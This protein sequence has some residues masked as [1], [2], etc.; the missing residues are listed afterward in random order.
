MEFKRLENE[1]DE[2][3]IY[4]VCSQKDAIGTWDDVKD[5]LNELLDC[6]YGESTYRKKFQAFQK[7]M[8]AN[9]HKFLDDDNYIKELR[10]E[11][12]ELAKEK[13][14]LSDER[15]ELNRQIRE[16]A[17]KESYLDM[18]KN[19]LCDNTQPFEFNLNKNKIEDL[20][21]LSNKDLIVHITDV[22]TGI[23]IDNFKNHF[24]EDTLKKRIEKYTSK[25][26]EIQE[27]HKAENCYIIASE[28]ISGLIH[29]NLRLQN[30]LDLMEQF[31]LVSLLIATMI[32]ELVLHFNEIY[33]YTV[34]GNHSRIVAKKE[35]SLQGENMDILFPFYL[36]AKL[37]NYPSVHIEENT[38]CQD[39]AI[40][41]VRGNNVFASHG[42]KDAPSSVVQN[43]TMMF[44]VKP[45]LI[46]LGHRHTNGM[47]TVYD[48]KVIESGCVSGTDQYA[49]SIRKCNRPEQTISVIDEN[50][51]VC[52]YDIQLD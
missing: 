19:V 16:Q 24:D 52:L 34:E 43:Y 42:D 12:Q 46:Y 31:K 17:R 6:D 4:R 35:D 36:E 49:L 23:F 27:L 20:C 11:R 47:T 50:G 30:N 2:E 25:I 48:T 41:N 5:V 1:S 28:L 21:I 18:V 38:I 29:N 44:G 26:I 3:L 32:K 13:Q 40:F 8:Q 45:N 14:K 37:Q 51:L 15:T 22:H 39:I 7:L 10:L 33:V 9:E